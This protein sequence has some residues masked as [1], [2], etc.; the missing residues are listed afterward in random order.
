MDNLWLSRSW[1]TRPR[2]PSDPP[3]AY[4]F[5]DRPTFEARAAEGGFLE[6]NTVFGHLYGTPVPDGSQDVLLEIDVQ[7]AADVRRRRPDAVVVLVLPP[8]RQEQERR[9]RERGDDME[10]IARRLAGADDEERAG[11]ALADHVVIND[12]LRRAV[13]EVVGIVEAHR[14]PQEHA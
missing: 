3:D 7:G 12:D 14:R 6:W 11:R 4:H 2:R 8:S 10:T 9:L 1:T 13:D 5:V